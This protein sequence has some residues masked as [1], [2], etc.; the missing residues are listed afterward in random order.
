MS[1]ES[2]LGDRA[3]ELL[4]VHLHLKWTNPGRKLRIF[5][6]LHRAKCMGND[7]TLPVY[8]KR[9]RARFGFGRQRREGVAFCDM[10]VIGGS[11][12]LA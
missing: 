6:I 11:I 1:R 9:L 12:E 5:C 3:E 10:L 8:Q 4:R 7:I 2:D